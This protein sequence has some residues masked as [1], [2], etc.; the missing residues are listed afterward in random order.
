VKVE[1]AIVESWNIKP[2]NVE[3]PNIESASIESLNVKI[4]AHAKGN[5][6]FNMFTLYMSLHT[7]TTT[8]ASAPPRQLPHHSTIAFKSTTTATL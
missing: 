1:P 4:V 7:T 3:S 5:A 6:P 2:A 8:T